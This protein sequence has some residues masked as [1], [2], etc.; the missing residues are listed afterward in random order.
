MSKFQVIFIQIMKTFNQYWFIL[1]LT[2]IGAFLRLYNIK[3]TIAFQGD[4]GRDVRI[5]RDLLQKADPILVGPTTSVGK[6]QLGPLYYYYMAPWLCLF[7]YDPVGP[8][9][10]VA[11]LGIVTIPIL[12][13]VLKKMFNQHVAIFTSVLYTFSIVVIQNTR[14]SWNPNPMPLVAILLIYS[15]YQAYQNKNNKQLALSFLWLAIGLQLHYMILLIVPFFVLMI[16]VIVK[17][18]KFQK[19]ILLALGKGVLIF[20]LMLTPLVIFE[21]RHDFLNSR[22]FLEFFQKGHHSPQIWYQPLLDMEGRIQTS[23][24][25]ILGLDKFRVWRNFWAILLFSGILCISWFKRQEKAIMII[26]AYTICS[27]VGMSL[28]KGDIFNHYLGFFFPIPFIIL[29]IWLTLLWRQKLIIGKIMVLM[30]LGIYTLVQVKQYHAL[31]TPLGWQI[32]DIKKLAE[33][34]SSDAKR[35]YNLILLDDSKDY[36]AMNYRYYSEITGNPPVNELNYTGIKT[37][38][39]IVNKQDLQQLDLHIWELESFIGRQ[40]NNLQNPQDTAII[41]DKIVKSWDYR[42]GPWLY[43]LQRD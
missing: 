22:G 16:F 31:F 23:I 1:L 15:L 8:A 29:G 33:E 27:I 26:L 3:P 17:E 19:E 20:M 37:I 13:F 32:D 6:I 34:V 30:I 38:Y 41:T 11:V 39:L 35:P 2:I 14:S 5:V 40:I 28:Y 25:N 36:R 10:G 24:G 9:V 4:Q 21:F 42:G 43:K 18:S 7:N 12:F